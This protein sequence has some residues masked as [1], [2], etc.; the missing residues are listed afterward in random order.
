MQ[1]YSQLL[2]GSVLSWFSFV[3][4]WFKHVPSLTR[5][6]ETVMAGDSTKERQELFRE[7]V[8]MLR[9]GLDGAWEHSRQV[10]ADLE[11]KYVEDATPP[12]GEVSSAY[13]RRHRA[14][15]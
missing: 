13:W 11:D 9:Q 8:V 6:F 5:R 14:K 15:P 1:A 4:A 7:L 3:E 12:S 2:A 10:L